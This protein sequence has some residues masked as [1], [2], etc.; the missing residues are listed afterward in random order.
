[1]LF[2]M[3]HEI[4]LSMVQDGRK[5]PFALLSFHFD[6]YFQWY[7]IFPNHDKHNVR[8]NFCLFLVLFYSQLLSSIALKS[9]LIF[10]FC[11]LYKMDDLIYMFS[12]I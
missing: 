6:P 4:L 5:Y 2:K 12:F 1:M 10:W 7:N 11:F 3:F 8:H 9:P